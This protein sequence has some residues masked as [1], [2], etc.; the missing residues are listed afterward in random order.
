MSNQSYT[1]SFTVDHTADEVFDAINNV[2]GWW[3]EGIEGATDGAGSEFTHRVKGVHYAKIRVT[4]FVPGKKVVWRVLENHLTFTSDP[5]EWQ[6]TEIRFDLAEQDGTTEVRFT[7][8][9]LVPSYECFDICSNAWG[10]YI[11]GSLRSLITTG[12]GNPDS[13]PDEER[14]QQEM[15]VG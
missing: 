5:T 10:L 14:Y 3:S 8:D 4:E 15:R 1:T 6:D 2:R 11:G 7:H 9:G 12:K 13:N